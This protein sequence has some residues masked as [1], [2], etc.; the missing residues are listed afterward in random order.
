M[1]PDRLR[2]L[3]IRPTLQWLG[4]PYDSPEAAT[5]LTAI[6]LQESGLQHR[7]QRPRGPARSFWQIEGPTAEAVLRNWPLAQDAFTELR[8][9]NGAVRDWLEWNDIG[10]CVIARGILW[11]EPT[12]LP[13][14]GDVHGAWRYYNE[15]CWRPGKPRQESWG[16]CYAE[17]LA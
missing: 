16:R 4:P 14:L 2:R 8:L 17:A 9:Q 15:R 1:T 3:V 12:P 10:A 11:L 7:R 6:A 13:L 5:L